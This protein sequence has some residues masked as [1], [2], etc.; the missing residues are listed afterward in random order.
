MGEYSG[1]EGMMLFSEGSRRRIRSMHKEIRVGQFQICV[2]L[3]A[4]GERGNLDLSK[5][6][7]LAADRGRFIAA[8]S[9]SK[10]VWAVMKRIEMSQ[11]LETGILNKAVAWPMYRKFPHA[12]DAFKDYMNTK[13]KS[14]F[15]GLSVE[16]KIL[17]GILGEFEKKL[18]PTAVKLSARV[19]VKCFELEGIDAVREALL[20][21]LEQDEG[22]VTAAAPGPPAGGAGAG[23]APPTQ[24][25]SNA[26]KSGGGGSKKKDKSTA[27]KS[28]EMGRIAIQV[29]APPNY[30]V[31]TLSL[32][33]EA[34]LAVIEKALDR[35]QTKILAAKGSF[36]V[37]S[38]PDVVL[39]GE[40]GGEEEEAAKGSDDD[41]S[42]DED[43][44]ESDD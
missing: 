28:R 7:V 27:A 5:R 17:D 15:N 9:K 31:T 14:I 10:T 43:E 41:G 23:A 37:L 26:S 13:D 12:L 29:V 44:D 8:Y 38:K 39:D 2:V 42:G 4:V 18:T 16:P 35:I 30:E 32:G 24:D 21:G 3:R 33:R 1:I 34:G 25:P 36:Q 11:K 40:G 6:R 22:E 19:E 20:A